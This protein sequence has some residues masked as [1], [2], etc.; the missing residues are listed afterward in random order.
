MRKRI[1]TQE[2]ISEVICNYT[3]PNYIKLQRKFDKYLTYKK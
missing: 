2:E 1:F 3:I